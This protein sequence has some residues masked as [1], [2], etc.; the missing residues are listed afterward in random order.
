L[1]LIN[2]AAAGSGNAKTIS[3][4]ISGPLT[5]LGVGDF[6]LTG[7]LTTTGQ[8][9]LSLGTVTLDGGTLGSAG[10]YSGVLFVGNNPGDN[11]IFTVKSGAKVY[12]GQ[13]FV[14]A[15]GSAR[16]TLTVMGA[17]S[18][19]NVNNVLS[20]GYSGGTQIG[21][22]DVLAGGKIAATDYITIANGVS[23]GSMTVDGAGSLVTTASQMFVGRN[24]NGSLYITA[25]G[26]VAVGTSVTIAENS[27]TL[28]SVLVDGANSQLT[29]GYHLRVGVAGTGTLTIRNGS[30]VASNFTQIGASAGANATLNLNAT[31]TLQTGTLYTGGPTAS[32]G[33][34]AVGSPGAATAAQVNF[35]GG[36]LRAIENNGSFINSFTAGQLVIASGGAFIDSNGFAIGSDNRF[37]GTGALTKLGAGTFTLTGAQAYSGGTTVR[38]GTLA[39]GTG[40]AIA[41]SGAAAL[42]GSLAGDAATLNVTD[43]GS[44]TSSTL[45]LGEAAGAQGSVSVTG[46]GSSW[47]AGSSV[48][49]GNFGSGTMNVLNGGAITVTVG[50]PTDPLTRNYVARSAGSTGVVNVDGAGSKWTSNNSLRIADYGTGTFSITNGGAV[51]AKQVTLGY[52]AG[53]SGVL[54]VSGAGSSLTASDFLYVGLYA[55]GPGSTA[56]GEVNISDGGLVDVPKFQ[57]GTL[58]AAGTGLGVGAISVDGPNSTL[59]SATGGFVGRS[60][61]GSLSV[62]N[63]ALLETG[64]GYVSIGSHLGSMGIVQVSSG[65]AWVN[66][67]D[68][69]LGL[70]DTV[71]GNSV[72]GAP[73]VGTL[74]ITG[75]STV[76]QMNAYLGYAPGT[77]GNATITGAGSQWTSD[78]S[79][80]VGYSGT[81]NLTISDGAEASAGTVFVGVDAGSTGQIAIKNGA[82]LTTKSVTAGD[83]IALRLMLDGGTLRA[84]G[85]SSDF[86]SGF[87]SGELTIAG[88]GGH[89]DTNGFVVT[90]SA[91]FDGTGAFFKDGDG[92]LNLLN[93]NTHTGGTYVKAGTLL[94]N[95][96]K[97]S[98]TGSGEVV[99]KD[100]A[101]LGGA[102]FIEGT[103]TIENG[104]HL[105][106]GNSPGTLTTGTLVLNPSSILD[107][108]LGQAGV[109]GGAF[110]DLTVVNG[111]LT[112]DG[113]LNVAE[114]AGGT[115]GA[116]I[117]RLFDYGGSLTNEKLDLGAL[118]AGAVGNVN[119][120]LQTSVPGQVNLVSSVGNGFHVWDGDVIANGTAINGAVDGGDGI[121]ANGTANGNWTDDAGELNGV[122]GNYSA[123][124]SGQ[125]GRVR[126][127]SSASGPVVFQAAEFRTDGYVIAGRTSADALSFDP[128][129]T[130]SIGAEPGVTGTFAVRLSGDG[131]STV[132]IKNS[133]TIVF[134]GNNDYLGQT[135]VD[136]DATLFID[137]DQSAATGQV[138]VGKDG[139]LGGRGTMGGEIYVE[140]DGHLL[141]QSGQTLS[142]LGSLKFENG[143]SQI[144]VM[145]GAADST[146]L[147]SMTGDLTLDGTLNITDAGGFGSGIYRLIDYQGTFVD[148]GLELG[149]VPGGYVPGTDLFI[150]TSIPGT[151]NL[152]INTSGI[153]F[154]Y[155]DGPGTANDSAVAGGD[156]T[157]LMGNPPAGTDFWTDVTGESNA[158]WTDN[159]RAVFAGRAGTVTVNGSNGLVHFSGADFLMGGYVIAGDGLWTDAAQTVVSVVPGAT[160]TFANEITG[161]GGLDK[162]GRGTLVLN[163]A[164]SYAGGTLVG[165][166]TLVAQ[167]SDALGE[168]NVRITSD[169]AGTGALI[170][171]GVNADKLKIENQGSL[172]FENGASASQADITNYYSGSGTETGRTIFRDTTT[173]GS[174]TIYNYDGNPLLGDVAGG[175]LFWQTS[176]AETATIINAGGMTEFFHDSTAGNATITN[177]ADGVTILYSG[178]GGTPSFGQARI[179]NNAGGGIFV[180]GHGTAENATIVNHAGGY[181]DI[182][183]DNVNGF[184]AGG[185][186]AFEIGSLSGD[187]AVYLG[188]TQLTLGRLGNDEAIGGTIADG[189]SALLI[190]YG[191]GDPGFT[192]GSLRKVGGGLLILSGANTYTGGTILEEGTLLMNRTGALGTGAVEVRQNALLTVADGGSAGNLSYTTFDQGRIQFGDGATAGSATITNTDQGRT[193]FVVGGVA[194]NATI[195]NQ[196]DGQTF[197]TG[198]SSAATATIL[199][200]PKGTTTFGD[201]ATA[202]D[203][204]ITNDTGGATQFG[205]SATAGQAVI[206]NVGFDGSTFFWQNSTAGNATITNEAAAFTAL[207]GDNGGTVSM[208]TARIINLFGGTTALAGNVDGWT[209]TIV[210]GA[211]GTVDISG[212]A[213]EYAVVPG[214]PNAATIGSLSGGGDVYLGKSTLTLGTLGRN[215]TIGGEIRDGSSPRLIQGISGDPGYTGG[216]LIKTGTGTLMLSAVNSYTGNTTIEQG[217]LLLEG[218]VASPSTWVRPD[219][220]LRGTGTVGGELR[221]LGLVAPGNAAPGTLWVTG[222]YA[223]DSG[224]TLG[225]RIGGP[226]AA[227]HDLLLIGGT[228]TLAGRIAFSRLIGFRFSLGEKITFLRA[229]AVDGTFTLT[230]NPFAT[231]RTIGAKVVYDADSVSLVGVRTSFETIVKDRENPPVEDPETRV[232]GPQSLDGQTQ[233]QLAAARALD[234]NVDDPRLKK[235]IAHLDNESLDKVLRDLDRLAP[236]EL[237]SLYQLSIGLARVQT[238]NLQRRLAAVRRGASGFSADG[239]TAPVAEGPGSAPDKDSQFVMEPN[240]DGRFGV[241]ITGVGE[242]TDVDSTANARGYKIQTGGF[243][244]GAD[245]KVTSN[246]A[247]GV[248]AGYANSDVDFTAN[249]HGEVDGGK[250]AL[251]ATC[252]RDGFYVDA[253][254]QG[255]L[256][257]YDYRRQSVNGSARG[258]TDGRELHTFLS[259][260]YDRKVGAFDV[261]AF[262]GLEY[263]R[264]GIDGFRERG[265]LAPLVAPD[266]HQDSIRS[267]LG[268][269]AAYDWRRGAILI[270]PEIRA[271]W[272]HE[273]GDANTLAWK[274]QLPGGT[275]TTFTSHGPRTA[276]DTALL[277]AGASVQWSENAAASLFYD[278]EFSAE[279][280]R[281]H[282]LSVSLK[283]QF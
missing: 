162:I 241:F 217:T 268:A 15:T 96:T 101:K 10:S 200:Q 76:S 185:T 138:L 34:I 91:A 192:G 61:K 269:R 278:A 70:Y 128:N 33:V 215:D 62:T 8:T 202:A 210:N 220:V 178:D 110:N 282:N 171:R 51:T 188:A 143:G 50:N 18:E 266:Q 235:L 80:Y 44:V 222:N 137:G 1:T 172:S 89:F 179:T 28:C 231:D 186:G 23:T 139:R 142:T 32:A 78:A 85:D 25:G 248:A 118:P 191:G 71:G 77:L 17:G 95:N 157:W 196:D 82:A 279:N 68:L 135:V 102:G 175:T 97:F 181:V 145:L 24:G 267:G 116:G 251:Y 203:A 114:S 141:G 5:K 275:G 148:N 131:S 40:G 281:S 272:Q 253:G 103:V 93:G 30:Y 201:S 94:V 122:W 41:H 205:G 245:C 237:T 121:W 170:F 56:G 239:F 160:A 36:T 165:S 22:I 88:G 7:A 127:E 277:S 52:F 3:S 265:S 155:W 195:S 9:T 207:S 53:S 258:R 67:G 27:G 83:G 259:G 54:N 247:V 66:S 150:Q 260:G 14:A 46:A 227:Q 75:G 106:P 84:S 243:T 11:A 158:G 261:G 180:G 105:A 130:I 218:S 216:S 211:G 212:T 74:N 167:A 12:A 64:L 136:S 49:V 125:A 250:L 262:A 151:V 60:G 209:G 193:D 104:A 133:G 16:G 38:A 119:V 256:N 58:S 134:A 117:Y 168:G 31:G 112:L 159:A 174:A 224:G 252:H 120:F 63:G 173:A 187:G 47:G 164:N 124:F 92:T 146:P 154:N 144:D 197:F 21:T 79:L 43:G 156:G 90:T 29:L 194:D 48:T 81:S 109:P 57:I 246:F 228:A 249:G 37:S 214:G 208:G 183:M 69:F 45:T 213:N 177:E 111:D 107:Y 230:L 166:G 257:R 152:V 199:N 149:V 161:S 263:T 270:R 99:V 176:S 19:L 72:G 221:N 234:A 189:S 190:A 219:G 100:G 55:S 26:R 153:I 169:F 244:L 87:D 238:L 184:L 86:I 163:H 6:R 273:F 225:I 73:A 283:L 271:A 65:S 108:E 254:V 206:R 233:N 182:S 242:R 132:L 42:V 198:S 123:I 39:I 140:S 274:A 129:A 4:T 59:R 2:N 240:N 223:Q 113:T 280:Y 204:T 147:F 226:T 35:N 276:R 13:T 264:V 20:T 126:V 98:A 115:F 229:A 232:A 236:E 255:G